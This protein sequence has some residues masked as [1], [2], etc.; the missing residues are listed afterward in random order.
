MTDCKCGEFCPSHFKFWGAEIELKAIIPKEAILKKR[1][2]DQEH[3]KG[4]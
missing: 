4:I 3:N 1:K 2:G